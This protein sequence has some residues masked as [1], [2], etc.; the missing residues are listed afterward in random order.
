MVCM[1]PTPCLG[2]AQ[3][4]VSA[5]GCGCRYCAASAAAPAVFV[6]AVVVVVVACWIGDES[7][8]ADSARE[9]CVAIYRR[10]ISYFIQTLIVRI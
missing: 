4:Q 10:S 9:P 8:R 7:R 1:A 5:V 3:S 6:V 2:R